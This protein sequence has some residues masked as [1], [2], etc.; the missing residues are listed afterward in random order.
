[1][2]PHSRTAFT[3]ALVLDRRQQSSAAAITAV[4]VDQ[5]GQRLYL[6]LEDGVLEEHA[7]LRTESGG[8]RASLAA[9]KHAT[10]K[11][12]LR[13]AGGGAAVAAAAAAHYDCP[14]RQAGSF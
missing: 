8:V 4:A 7:I 2:E 5:A 13:A 9:R 14:G 6:G 11:V 3:A 10:K 1:M 12:R